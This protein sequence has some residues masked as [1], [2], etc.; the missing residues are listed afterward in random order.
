[1]QLASLITLSTNSSGAQLSASCEEISLKDS[2]LRTLRNVTHVH[3]PSLGSDVINVWL[4]ETM[5]DWGGWGVRAKTAAMPWGENNMEVLHS[6]CLM[7][8]I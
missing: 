4:K 2:Y 6:S 8:Q 3:Y 5:K 1:M 7:G